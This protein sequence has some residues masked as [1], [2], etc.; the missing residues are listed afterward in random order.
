MKN[1]IKKTIHTS[2][3]V[4]TKNKHKDITNYYNLWISTRI[5]SR[6]TGEVTLLTSNK[7]VKDYPKNFYTTNKNKES[8]LKTIKEYIIFVIRKQSIY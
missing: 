1:D 4:D 3:F 6:H 5:N 7:T 2:L 8:Q